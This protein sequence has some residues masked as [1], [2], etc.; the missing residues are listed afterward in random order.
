MAKKEYLLYSARGGR[1]CAVRFLNTKTGEYL[2]AISLGTQN[3]KE[4]EKIIIQWLKNGIPSKG[5]VNE[6]EMMNFILAAIKSKDFN[7]NSASE[8]LTALQK[9]GFVRQSVKVQDTTTPLLSDYIVS[10]WNREYSTYVKERLATGKTMGR[11]H[12]R[13]MLNT[14]KKH[15]LPVFGNFYLSEMNTEM[16]NDFLLECQDN[17]MAGSTINHIAQSICKP[18]KYAYTK[19]IIAQNIEIGLLKFA[20][21]RKERGILTY[22]EVNELFSINWK[23][24]RSFTACL[25]ASQTGMR[26]GEIL[27]LRKDDIGLDRL[28]I[29]HSWS[30]VDGLKTT[31]TGESRVVPLMQ[32]TREL[33]LALA[34]DE[35]NLNRY[36]ENPYI[37]YSGIPNVPVD[38]K[39]ISKNFYRALE[40][41]GIT[42]KERRERSIVFHSWRHYVAT[43]LANNVNKRT[44]MSITGHK[45]ERTYAG[46]SSHETDDEFNEKKEALRSLADYKPK[47]K[48]EN[49]K[50]S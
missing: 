19:K 21:K 40:L 12:C 34:E 3:K 29:R 41:I 8:V 38:K 16:I 5:R 44:G 9:R 27:A 25:L 50:F 14:A 11:S 45:N 22:K 15:I 2:P 47:I 43:Y 1:N 10:F 13:N 17:G 46:Y 35:N 23:C 37:F 7:L 31:K 18:L 26:I 20:E 30:E 49:I 32:E 4:A 6:I 39:V 42:E 33:L 48:N 24:K 28:F 36:F